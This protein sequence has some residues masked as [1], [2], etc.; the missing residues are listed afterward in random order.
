MGFSRA[1][2]GAQFLGCHLRRHGEGDNPDEQAHLFRDRKTG[3][4]QI[5]ALGFR[6]AEQA[7]DGP[8]LAVSGQGVM[9]RAIADDD[10]SPRTTARSSQTTP[11]YQRKPA[12]TFSSPSLTIPGN[13]A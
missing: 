10:R 7:F 5:E 13:V 4:L 1:L 11:V 8:P 6:F 12:Q 3:V 9:G 2:L